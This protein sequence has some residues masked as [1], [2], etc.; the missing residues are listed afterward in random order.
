MKQVTLNIPEN[1]YELFMEF[2][3][4]IDF[5]KS[6][7]EIDFFISKEEQTLILDRIKKT[8]KEDLKQLSEVIDGFNLE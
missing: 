2:I 1:K 5:I 6:N 3:K 4:N 7:N 8:K